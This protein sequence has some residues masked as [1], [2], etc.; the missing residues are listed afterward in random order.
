MCG[1][2]VRRGGR[3]RCARCS[4]R[5]SELPVPPSSSSEE[6]RLSPRS[7]TLGMCALLHLPATAAAP[8]SSAA[9]S[10]RSRRPLMVAPRRS[11]F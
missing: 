1:S 10:M 11:S 7:P 3:C 6:V 5:A 8:A 2:R 9:S 4:R